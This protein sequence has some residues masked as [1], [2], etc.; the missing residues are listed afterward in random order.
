[1]S[2]IKKSI[3]QFVY[4][5]SE[6]E[7]VKILIDKLRSEHWEM[8]HKENTE[9]VSLVRCDGEYKL[10]FE[11]KTERAIVPLRKFK[12]AEAPTPVPHI[13]SS[14]ELFEKTLAAERRELTEAALKEKLKGNP[15]VA[16]KTFPVARERKTNSV[17]HMVREHEELV[18]KILAMNKSFTNAQLVEEF[19]VGY[20]TVIKITR[21]L[22]EQN[23]VRY[24]L[25]PRPP[26]LRGRDIRL[27]AV[28]K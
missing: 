26:G 1:M 18:R 12:P 5:F 4:K 28:V 7:L 14:K 3:N 13:E 27:Y 19:G 16:A 10:V 6:D 15:A 23:K 8:P 17:N 2:H 24:T 11:L 25:L 20:S 22:L 9:E 21:D